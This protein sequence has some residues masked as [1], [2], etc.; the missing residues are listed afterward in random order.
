MRLNKKHLIGSFAVILFLYLIYDSFFQPSEK[1]LKGN[2][3]EVSFFRNEQNTGPII[4]IYAVTVSDTLWK[5]MQTYGDYKPHNKYGN[6]K[7]YFFLNSGP[8]PTELYEGS[9][10]FDEQ[11]QENCIA[12]YEKGTMS[13]VVLVKHPFKK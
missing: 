3:T 8:A 2:L 1:D 12:K 13:Q 5:E 4:R 6:T 7:V 9:K 11:Y 10:N